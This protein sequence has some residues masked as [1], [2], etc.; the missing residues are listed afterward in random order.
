M[1]SP[2]VGGGFGQKN[3][4]QMQTVLA[5]VAARATRAAGEAGGAARA[6]SSTMRASARRAGIASGSAPTRSGKMVAAIHEVDAQTSRHDLFPGE[7]TATQL[8]PL[9][10]S[11][12]SAAVE[13]L[14][15]TDVQTPGYH[16][17]AVRASGLLRAWNRCVDELAYALGQDPVALRL[18]NDTATDPV[19]GLA[20]LL[21]P[22]GRMPAARRGAVRLGRA[23]H[24][25]AIDARPRTAR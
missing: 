23:H 15:R 21:P 6:A 9:R 11:R 13:R 1:I 14:V 8:A 18:A 5:A 25:A 22:C 20:L 12:I 10:H 16:A 4:L 19:T 24:G 17:R 7:Y 3:S 2:F